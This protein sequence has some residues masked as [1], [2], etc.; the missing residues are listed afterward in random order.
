MEVA[1]ASAGAIVDERTHY[2]QRAISEMVMTAVGWYQANSARTQQARNGTLG[3]SDLGGCREFLRASI[4]RDPRDDSDEA[5][6]AAFCGTGIGDVVEKAMQA[7]LGEDAAQLQRKLTLRLVDMN[8][9]VTGSADTVLTIPA[10]HPILERQPHL[11]SGVIDLKTKDELS[12][13]RREGPSLKEKIQI[14]GYLVAAFQEGLLG[15]KAL[16]FLVF[17]DR[18]GA[19]RKAHTWAV[20]LEG[21]YEYLEIAEKRLQDVAGAL[22]SGEV[23]GYL[24]DEPEQW[25]VAVGCPFRVACWEGYVPDAKITNPRFIDA[26][27]RYDEGRE[28]AKVADDLKKGAKSTLQP[29]GKEDDSVFGRT[30]DGTTLKWTAKSTASG[31]SLSIDVRVPK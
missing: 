19:D 25:C 22:A 9:E 17:L 14:S 24:R 4:A 31:T 13:V 10:G 1:I 28:L 15:E 29:G 12:T 30:P 8:I 11:V 6:W 23:G 2:A 5:K 27:R 16:G 26:L 18:S 7:Y 21:A 20:D 3:F